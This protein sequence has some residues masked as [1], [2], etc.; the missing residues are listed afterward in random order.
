MTPRRR[1]DPRNRTQIV[2]GCVRDVCD[3]L[4]F[5][6]SLI[7]KNLQNSPKTRGW[8]QIPYCALVDLSSNLVVLDDFEWF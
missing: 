8:Q 5:P 3:A 4:A 2:S 6:R 7:F 1:E